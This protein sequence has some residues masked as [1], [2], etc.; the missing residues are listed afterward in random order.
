MT[1]GVRTFLNQE[2]LKSYK[3]TNRIENVRSNDYS[4]FPIRE[5]QVQLSGSSFKTLKRSMF[6]HSSY[7]SYLGPGT[8][9]HKMQI[10]LNVNVKKL[11]QIRKK[12]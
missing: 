8:H 1:Y 6:P 10:S 4:L 2:K 5:P 7:L 12:S 3:I 9:R 11:K